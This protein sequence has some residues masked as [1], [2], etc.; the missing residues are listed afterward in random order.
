MRDGRGA[1]IPP[2]QMRATYAEMFY[3]RIG[4]IA[5]TRPI[6]GKTAGVAA[7]GKTEAVEGQGVY[8]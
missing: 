6:L 2:M 4:W 5:K 1:P 3:I 8:L 7:G